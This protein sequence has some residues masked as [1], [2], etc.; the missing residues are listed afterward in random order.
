MDIQ[1]FLEERG[2]DSLFSTRIQSLVTSNPS[3]VAVFDAD[4]TLWAGD[5]GETL[6]LALLEKGWLQGEATVSEKLRLYHEKCAA[7]ASEAYGW[8]VQEMA[9]LKAT[10]VELLA[11][12]VMVEFVAL[13]GFP[14]MIA[15]AQCLQANGWQ[16]WL[17][18]ASSSLVVRAGARAAGLRADRVLGVELEE[19]ANVL[20][21]RLTQVPNLEGKVEAI[22]RAGLR[23]IL[24]AGNSVNDIPM[25][26]MAGEMAISVNP[27]KALYSMAREAGWYSMT[28]TTPVRS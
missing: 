7:D 19:N 15:L 21:R 20:Q 5:C 23:P 26:K 8:I 22:E 18:S 3:G 9:G 4:G 11:N 16:S 24:A 1:H 13:E 12:E 25:L 10:E 28:C 14:P 6:F 2:W 17:V 27:S